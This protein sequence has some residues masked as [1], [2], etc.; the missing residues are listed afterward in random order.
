M[1]LSV[2]ETQVMTLNQGQL[3]VLEHLKSSKSH[4]IIDGEGGCGK[5]YLIGMF[6]VWCQENDHTYTVCAPS[7]QA[8]ANL[9]E[10][11]NATS[12]LLRY[13]KVSTVQSVLGQF[14][15]E[16]NY[17]QLIFRN[18][19]AEGIAG[20]LGNYVIIDE[21]SM[22]NEKQSDA[23]ARCGSKLVCL[24]DQAQLP[25]VLAKKNSL[26]GSAKTLTLTE[27]MRNGGAIYEA[28]HANRTSVFLP[29][30][31]KGNL[32]VHLDVS[33]HEDSFLS[34]LSKPNP[35]QCVY[36]SYKN[37]EVDR[38]GELSHNVLYG[39][40]AFVPGQWLMLDECIP[41]VQVKGRKVIVT[42]VLEAKN[43]DGL[44]AYVVEVK[45]PTLDLK[46]TITVMEPK[47]QRRLDKRLEGWMERIIKLVDSGDIE[48][49]RLLRADYDHLDASITRTLSPFSLTVHK[50]QGGTIPEVWVNPLEIGNRRPL[51]YVA[52]SRASLHLH[53]VAPVAKVVTVNSAYRAHRKAIFANGFTANGVWESIRKELTSRGV[54][55]GTDEGKLAYMEITKGYLTQTP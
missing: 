30:E 2:K 17:G 49:A 28:A 13:V 11:I 37:S 16:D 10:R 14:A 29:T 34:R 25:P 20:A 36:L 48:G 50:S 31:S 8:V 15:F 39:A 23:L 19:D 44:P 54:S 45:H 32:T 21:W 4:T 35:E 42:K 3:K 52:F 41:N 12:G 46:I 33:A 51:L 22:V 18:P 38:M 9:E 7:H 47:I 43:I 5:T 53:T 40:Q 1:V 27:Q 6:V 26:W 24:G 55:T